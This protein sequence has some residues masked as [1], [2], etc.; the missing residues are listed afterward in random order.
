M[1]SRPGGGGRLCTPP[2]IGPGAL[3]GRDPLLHECDV[4][5]LTWQRTDAEAVLPRRAPTDAGIKVKVHRWSEPPQGVT[6]LDARVHADAELRRIVTGIAIAHDL[7]HDGP[8]TVPAL[9]D[10]ITRWRGYLDDDAID[11]LRRARRALARA[12]DG[13]DARPG[14][15]PCPDLDCAD[16]H[17]M[18]RAQRFAFGLTCPACGR[19]WT[20]AD[21]LD[22]LRRLVES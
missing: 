6:I 8:W 17:I 15:V 1:N 5:M 16:A 10:R 2:V 12:L 21:E 20:G 18:L 19:S 22:R 3:P 7:H 11:A 9:V 4:L 13:H 14:I